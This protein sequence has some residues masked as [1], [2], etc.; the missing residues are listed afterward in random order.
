YS[1]IEQNI[2]QINN[3]FCYQDK[4]LFG[5]IQKLCSTPHFVVAAVRLPGKTLNLC[6]GRGADHTG[7]FLIERA[8]KSNVR[9]RDQFLEYLRKFFNGSVLKEIVLDKNDRI[10]HFYT[11]REEDELFTFFWKGRELFFSHLYPNIHGY[12]LFTSWRGKIEGLSLDFEEAKKAITEVYNECGRSQTAMESAQTRDAI[13]DISKYENDLGA[14]SSKSVKKKEKFLVRKIANIKADLKKV[15]TKDKLIE[16][17]ESGE[18][19]VPEGYRVNILGIKFKFES[20]L[21]EWGKRN[22]IYEKVKAFKRAEVILRK[23][24]EETQKEQEKVSEGEELV[25]IQLPPTITPIWN[26][27]KKKTANNDEQA[28]LY[29]YKFNNGVKFAV[30]AKDT[31]N[32]YLRS[33]WAKKED[34]WF[35][36]DGYPSAHLIVKAESISQLSPDDLN[37]IGSCLVFHSNLNLDRPP[38]MYTQVKNLKGIKGQ[39]GGVTMKKQKYLSVSFL[40]D[41]K[42]R[43]AII[44]V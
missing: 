21:N 30:G 10:V 3:E 5:K 13:F 6:L 28:Q 44:G 40:D 33:K 39:K 31:A 12:E 32:D 36:V 16:L 34:L 41:W 22:L 9:I 4:H 27:V 15:E 42:E 35:H 25:K 18:W 26:N 38:L 11:K 24:L 23:R 8:P 19:A 2:K 29:E 43:I 20:G 7:P 14:L 1:E 17:L 37:I